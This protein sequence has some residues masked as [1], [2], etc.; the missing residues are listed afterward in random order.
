[1]SRRDLLIKF[2]WN[3]ELIDFFMVSEEED[4]K[5]DDENV[6]TYDEKDTST[7][8]LSSSFTSNVLQI[9]R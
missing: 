5:Q 2:G 9:S 7:F 8:L 3:D 6:Y 1:M 4:T